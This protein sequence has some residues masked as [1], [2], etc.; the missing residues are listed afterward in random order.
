MAARSL[1]KP[2]LGALAAQVFLI[3]LAFPVWS[4]GSPQCPTGT[5]RAEEVAS[6]P[7]ECGLE[8]LTVTDHGVGAA[9][10]EPGAGVRAEAWTEAGLQELEIRT[11]RD[12]E[13]RLLHV[14]DDTV[15]AP[16]GV[17]AAEAR[18]RG[19]PCKTCPH[20][21]RDGANKIYGYVWP[22]GEIFEWFF[23]QQSTPPN[24][25]VEQAETALI[26]GT[27]NVVNARNGCK[28]A[29]NLDIQA[30]YEGDTN[31]KANFGNDSSCDSFAKRDEVNVVDFSV[32][33]NAAGKTCAWYL[34]DSQGNPGALV[35]SDVRILRWTNWTV[36]PKRKLGCNDM[37]DLEGMATHERA[38]TFGLGHVGRK[39]GNLTMSTFGLPEC[40]AAYR[41]FGLGDVRGLEKLY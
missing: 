14:G 4:A 34:L 41:T 39:H 8:G 10:P 26:N 36:Q 33:L 38:H 13:V 32:L 2:L 35:E 30:S 37:F 24:L 40:S 29:D 31:A 5:I 18:L 6:L 12:G 22:T 25:T 11:D 27:N 16:A 1:L 21:C 17:R 28:L 19:Q 20:P 23:N 3:T 9:V 7:P 15:V